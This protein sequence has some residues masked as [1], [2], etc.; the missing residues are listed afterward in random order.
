MDVENKK[1]SFSKLQYI[2]WFDEE[3]W[4]Y[5]CIIPWLK[6]ELTMGR[7]QSPPGTE[8]D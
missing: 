6:N 7:S 1:N 2:E 5:D 8:I 3:S 4:A